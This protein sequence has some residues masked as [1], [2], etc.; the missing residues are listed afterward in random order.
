MFKLLRRHPHVS[1]SYLGSRR[2]K[3]PADFQGRTILPFNLKEAATACELLFLAL[4]HGEA[5]KLAPALLKNPD[6]RII[7]FSGDFRIKSAA[8]F[9]QAYGI[10]HTAGGWLAKAVYGLPEINRSQIHGRLVANP[11][12]YP[13][14]TLLALAPLARKRLQRGGDRKSTRLNSS[15]GTLSRMPSSA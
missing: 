6:L 13:T 9:R 2:L 5:M 10:T 8:V 15:H 3:T 12:C 11:G 4:P 1:V 7:D 14:A